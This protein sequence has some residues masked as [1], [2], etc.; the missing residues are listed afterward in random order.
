MTSDRHIRLKRI[1]FRCWHRGTKEADLILGPFA[2]RCL[3]SLDDAEVAAL[4][5]LLEA[6]DTDFVKWVTGALPP[7]AEHDGPL[8]ARIVDAYRDGPAR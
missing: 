2:D 6:P 8:L 4:E 3:A 1:R 7:A 5:G